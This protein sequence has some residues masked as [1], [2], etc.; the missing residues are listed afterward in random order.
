MA[1]KVFIDSDVI[2]DFLLDREPH[3]EASTKIL[4]LGNKQII[5]IYTSTLCLNNVH[6]IIRRFLSEKKSREVLSELMA[7]INTVEVT[8]GDLRN[9]LTSDFKDFED[10]VQHQVAL[11]IEGIKAILTRNLKDFKKSKVA[12]FSPDAFIRIF[13]IDKS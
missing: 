7:I 3:A 1:F 10:G 8:E 2:I 6:Y 11:K 4:E 9:S 13:D 12:V 5:T